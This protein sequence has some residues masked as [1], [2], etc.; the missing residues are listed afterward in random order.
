MVG[1]PLALFVFYI[2]LALSGFVSPCVSLVSCFSSFLLIKL[3]LR[4]H[5][6]PHLYVRHGSKTAW[7]VMKEMESKQMKSMSCG[8]SKRVKPIKAQPCWASDGTGQPR[9]P[10]P[11]SFAF[12]SIKKGAVLVS[13]LPETCQDSVFTLEGRVVNS[14]PVLAKL[15]LSCKSH[16]KTLSVVSL[17]LCLCLIEFFRWTSDT[18][19]ILADQARKTEFLTFRRTIAL[20]IKL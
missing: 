8:I 20:S 3:C 1:I 9:E 16:R 15:V 5:L 7:K 4:S 18:K 14:W 17:L 11:S 19:C 13:I 10:L 6:T 2:V 12:P